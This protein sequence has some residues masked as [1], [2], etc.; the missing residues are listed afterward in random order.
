MWVFPKTIGFLF[1]FFKLHMSLIYIEKNIQ[2]SKS[3]YY[4]NMCVFLAWL[5]EKKY[6]NFRQENVITHAR[7]G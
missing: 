5:D 4:G 6:I 7:G 2:V 3:C 1:Y